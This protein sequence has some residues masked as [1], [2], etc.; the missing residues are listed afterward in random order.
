VLY[1]FNSAFRPLYVKNVLN[2]LSLPSGWTNEYR[3][4]ATGDPRYVSPE[5]YAQLPALSTGTECVI[6]F[7]DRF[8]EGG[9]EYHPLR[10]GRYLSYGEVDGKVFFNI[11]LGAFIY[12][13]SVIGFGQHIVQALSTHGLPSLTNGDPACT[14]DGSYVVI[15]G[16]IFG[17]PQDHFTGEEA[18]AEAV[19]KLA[20]TRA[21]STTLTDTT[22]FFRSDVQERSANG[23]HLKP[24][25]RDGLAVYAFRKDRQYDLSLTYRFPKQRTDTSAHAKVCIGFDDNLRALGD[26]MLTIDSYANR[27]STPF[28]SKRYVEDNSGRISLTSTDET[29]QPSVVIFDRPLQYELSESVGFWLQVVLA[30]LLFSLAGAFIGVDFSKISPFSFGALWGAA[31]TKVVA[32]LFQFG[33]LFWGFRLIGKKF[34]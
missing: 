24:V 4:R 22:V 23:T 10:R 34:L 33:A 29:G 20:E 19:E 14:T 31:W 30:L 7:I 28:R 11:E 16:D 17:R 26:T 3:Y 27:I 2:T 12:P 1:L 9:Y 32:A 18:W 21:F 13:R 5:V 25:L 6:V 8:G 15:A